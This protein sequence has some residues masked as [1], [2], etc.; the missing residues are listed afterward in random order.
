MRPRFPTVKALV[1]PFVVVAL[2]GGPLAASASAHLSAC[3]SSFVPGDAPNLQTRMSACPAGTTYTFATGIY[4]LTNDLLPKDGDKLIGAGSGAGGT[5]LS[6]SKV[7]TGWTKSGGLWIHTGDAL[8]VGVMPDPCEDGTKTCD[9][10]DWLFRDDGWLQRKLSPCTTL[11]TDQ[12]CVDYTAKKIYIGSDPTGHLF[13]YGTI[14]QLFGSRY[15]NVTVEHLA[16]NDFATPG[17]GVSAGAGWLIDDVY[18]YHNHSCGIVAS[19]STVANPAV[20]ENSVFDHNGYHGYCSP[21]LGVKIL[22]NDFSYNNELGFA[23]GSGLNIHGES[24][25]LV[26]GN[27]VDDN[28]GT[29][30]AI[31]TTNGGT[32]SIGVQVLGNTA[33]NNAGQGIRLDGSCNTLIDSNTITGNTDFAVEVFDSNTNTISNNTIVV[34][35]DAYGGG[36]RIRADTASGSSA[37]GAADDARNNTVKGNDITMGIVVD[38][39]NFG[40]INGTVSQG[41]LLGNETFLANDY[42]LPKGDCTVTNWLW[43]SGSTQ[44]IVAFSPW[45]STYGLDPGPGG[46][47]SS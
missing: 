13:E 34:P 33:V 26:Q 15:T 19:P 45:Q 38:H 24:G 31:G 43:W 42:H 11:S 37:C 10:Q 14:T 3:D 4:H 20:I 40:N 9:Y 41:G 21:S 8:K 23:H 25:A 35:S 6:G 22:N 39:G 47:C 28:A 32:P 2:V 12:F 16:Y 18:G 46:S 44:H 27:T 7:I 36:V 29:G 1:L 17:G 30:I 5:R